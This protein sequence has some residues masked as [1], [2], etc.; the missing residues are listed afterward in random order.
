MAN[1]VYFSIKSEKVNVGVATI[2]GCLRLGA[3]DKDKS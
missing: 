1:S 3:P 2:L